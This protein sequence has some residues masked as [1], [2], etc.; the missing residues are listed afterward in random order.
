M[1]V[2]I[3]LTPSVSSSAAATV[4][5]FA[6][7]SEAENVRVLWSP[8]VAGSVSTVRSVSP[9]RVMVTVTA[10]TGWRDGAT[11]HV[12]E[13]PSGAVTALADSAT[14]RSLSVSVAVTTGGSRTFDQL[15]SVLV[16]ACSMVARPCRSSPSSAAA[17]VTVRAVLQL[18]V[19]KVSVPWL[20]PVTG[21]VSRVRLG[22]PRSVVVTVTS[23][24]GAFVSFSV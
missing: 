11:V 2:A 19:V 20:P 12:A 23:A 5:V 6:L 7:Q 18:P 10:A 24:D 1:K 21:S 9:A 17:T 16:T 3:P 8:V 22:S 15:G 14:E 13:P 4:T